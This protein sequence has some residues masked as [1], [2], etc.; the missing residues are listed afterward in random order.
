MRTTPIQSDRAW[1]ST[2][3]A[4]STRHSKRT[5]KCLPFC[6]LSAIDSVCEKGQ[7]FCKKLW[8]ECATFCSFAIFQARTRIGASTKITWNASNSSGRGL[9]PYTRWLSELRV[10][11]RFILICKKWLKPNQPKIHWHDD[12]LVCGVRKQSRYQP[13]WSA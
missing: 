1:S 8:N 4:C 6:T 12:V 9:A 5:G 3:T 11:F 13:R 2:R 10:N 7:N